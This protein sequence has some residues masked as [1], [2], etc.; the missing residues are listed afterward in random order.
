M[1]SEMRRRR[2]VSFIESGGFGAAPISDGGFPEYPSNEP[3]TE[4]ILTYSSSIDPSVSTLRIRTF[5]VTTPSTLLPVIIVGH[6]YEQTAEDIGDDNLRRF[7]RYGYLV[8][9]PELRGSAG[10]GG[11]SGSIDAA[12]REVYDVYDG[13]VYALS[14]F[15]N[16]HPDRVSVVG[17]S[18]GG[19]TGLNLVTRFPDLFQVMVDYF[20]ISDYGSDTT[21]G[22]YQQAAARQAS[23]QTAIGGTPAAK[24]DEYAARYAKRDIASN[25]TGYLFMF[26]DDQDASVDVS[27]SQRVRDEYVSAGRTDYTYIQTTTGSN[28]RADHEYPSGSNTLEGFEAYW[29]LK[30]KTQA[31]QTVPTSGTLEINGRLKTKRFHIQM[32]DANYL[33]AG[34]SRIGTVVYDTVANTYSITN[35]STLYAVVTVLLPDGRV[36]TAVLDASETFV[37][38]PVTIVVDGDTPVVWL[39]AASKKLLSVADVTVISDKTG[40]PQCQGYSFQFITARPALLATDINSL[41]AIDFNAIGTEGLVGIRHPSLQGLGAFTFISVNTGAI[42][43][44][45]FSAN[46]QTQ[47]ETLVVATN[48]SAVNNGSAAN[49]SDAQIASYLVRTTI[50]DGSGGSNAT[51]LIRRENKVAQALTF[52]GTIPAATE[53]NASSVF[54]IGKRSYS[55]NYFGGKIAEFMIFNSVL[56]DVGDK[57]DILKAKYAI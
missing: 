43:D 17:F 38:T 18:G 52:S 36:A 25:F 3:L 16:A 49:G 22:W 20:G 37:L 44:H 21:Y 26:H 2:I 28:P 39:D 53:S 41:P 9:A 57:E 23:L 56:A 7:A 15:V 45:G 14:Q 10:S 46:A 29:K 42:V 12:G 5:Q 31:V 34:R 55:A 24:P 19:G 47:F 13:Y 11:N 4:Q 1:K 48:F 32:T 50:F 27:H 33:N 30:P 6:G 51:R 8:L 40:G 54:G 35:N